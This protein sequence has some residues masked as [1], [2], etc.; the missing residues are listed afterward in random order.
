[1]S[2]PNYIALI[3]DLVNSR[4]LTQRGRVQ[5]ELSELLDSLSQ[6][7]TGAMASPLTLT[8]GDEFQ[9]VW[10]RPAGLWQVIVGLQAGL[11]PVRVRLSLGLGTLATP[12]NPDAALGMDGEAFW[13]ARA[14]ID[15]MKQ[16]G[17]RLALTGLPDH[18]TQ[19][20][21]PLLAVIDSMTG[22]WK[23]NRWSIL[24]GLLA[25]ESVPDIADRLGISL[26]AVYRNIRD[27]ELR[28]IMDLFVL[29]DTLVQPCFSDKD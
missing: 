21:D 22:T 13:H 2:Q 26:Q 6:T 14:G 17:R 20:S 5:H 9:A 28:L 27:G 15:R 25:A 24:E 3:G 10:E 11:Y 12:I 8:L 23:A 7:H 19:W 4:Q 1:M 16:S 18:S 29:L